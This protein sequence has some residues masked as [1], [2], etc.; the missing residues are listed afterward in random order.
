MSE[1]EKICPIL[2]IGV[3][4]RIGL[5]CCAE[6]SCAWWIIRSKIARDKHGNKVYE[7][8][9]SCAIAQIYSDYR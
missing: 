3:G 5:A 6:G 9:G 4:S 8:F 1:N 7:D 2:S